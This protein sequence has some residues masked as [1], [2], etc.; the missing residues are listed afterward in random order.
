M[1][2]IYPLS[3]FG[4]GLIVGMTGVG[5]GA[6]MTPILVLLFG[7]AP[8]TAIG[9][10]L[11]FAAIT[12]LFGM[13]AHHSKGSVDW[14]VF[15]RLCLGSLPAA[16]LTNIY[17]YQAGGAQM[18]EGFL[19]TA[20]GC[21]L[22][23]TALA[24]LFKERLHTFGRSLRIGTPQKFKQVQPAMTV[25]AGA[26][27]GVLVTLTSIGA[28][29]LGATLLLYLYPLRLTTAKLVGTDIAHAIPLA[30]VAGTGHLI[31]GRV[32]GGLLG[33]LLLGS[34]PGV[35][36]GSKLTQLVPDQILRSGVAVILGVVG[37]KM[38]SF[39]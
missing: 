24:M 6:L 19:I 31:A 3:G 36:I 11:W 29:A 22:V 30:V 16:V 14:Q 39:H 20:L 12:K 15:R 13:G 38:L 18:K 1:D 35:V 5:G 4:V 2:W 34:I 10:D 21:V 9:T 26:L 27:L 32:D 37:F 25:V 7:V 23:L 33:S 8:G 17:L 28:G